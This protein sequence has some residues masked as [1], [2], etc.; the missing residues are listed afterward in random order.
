MFLKNS[1]FINTVNQEVRSL[2]KSQSI[3]YSYHLLHLIIP[4]FIFSYLFLIINNAS[5]ILL[6]IG[7][8]LTGVAQSMSGLTIGHSSGHGSFKKCNKIL[9]FLFSDVFS[10]VSSYLWDLQHNKN[11]HNLCN[12]STEGK[13]L[14][15]DYKLA[16]Q[17]K[18]FLINVP[19]FL[20]VPF[21]FLLLCF[22]LLQWTLV[23]DFITIFQKR[24]D[25]KI[26]EF[27]LF[28]LGKVSYIT[29]YYI[30]PF[31]F[32]SLPLFCT[33]VILETSIASF[34]LSSTF[35]IAH[36]N[37]DVKKGDIGELT[38]SYSREEWQIVSSA[39]FALNN[40]IIS[41]YTGGLNYQIEHHLFPYISPY[42][43][44]QIS[45]IIKKHLPIHVQY[46]EYQSFFVGLKKT[47]KYLIS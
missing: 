9:F 5:I 46:I 42:F 13:E 16:N 10:G 37:G 35:L 25:V 36:V 43:Y 17:L 40:S 21:L 30:L 7:A 6:I 44:P 45:K 38:K 19:S 1:D 15:I 4:I 8:A 26:N 18:L 2:M 39:N 23:G 31:I 34:V 11:H 32:L 22:N 14:D 47:I 3:P 20:K 27:L 12:L 41:F 29:L 28:L 33:L 24:K